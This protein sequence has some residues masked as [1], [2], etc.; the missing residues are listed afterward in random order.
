MADDRELLM[1]RPDEALLE[2]YEAAKRLKYTASYF[3]EML[4]ELAAWKR[5][6]IC[7]GR[8]SH[9]RASRA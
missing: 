7:F 1:A 8:T 3:F 9:L 5:R 2:S 6:A 4:D